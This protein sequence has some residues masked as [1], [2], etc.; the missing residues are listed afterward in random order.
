MTLFTLLIG[1]S[2]YIINRKIKVHYENMSKTID[3]FN[4]N[5]ARAQEILEKYQDL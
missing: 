4:E 2:F 5:L 1:V 3:M